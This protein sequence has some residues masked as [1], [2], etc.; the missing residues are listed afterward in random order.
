[1]QSLSISKIYSILSHFD[2]PGTLKTVGQ[3]RDMTVISTRIQ[4]V[5]CNSNCVISLKVSCFFEQQI[6]IRC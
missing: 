4:L 1:M 5:L 3:L 2:H 6:E